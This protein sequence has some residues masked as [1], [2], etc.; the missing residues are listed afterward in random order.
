MARQV[1]GSVQPYVLGEDIENYLERVE[2]YLEVNEVDDTRKTG[3]LLT[4]GGA[5]LFDVARKV[6][7][8]QNPRNLKAD[9]LIGI[10]KQHLKATVNE[11]A[12]R[13]KFRLVYQ[14]ELS[15]K[16]YIIELKAAAQQCNFEGFLKKALRDQLVAGVADQELR[17]K[18][19]A[20][21]TLD[22]ET[23]CN[24]AFQ[25][26]ISCLDLPREC[27]KELRRN[28]Q[29]L[30]LCRGCTA[31]RCSSKESLPPCRDDIAVHVRSCLSSEFAA[32]FN[33]LRSEPETPRMQLDS[34]TSHRSA[35]SSIAHH[36]QPSRPPPLLT[37]TGQQKSRALLMV[38]PAEAKFW[39]YL[40]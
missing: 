16:D 31:T 7:A 32:S 26:H 28:P 13:Y 17:K 33:G 38:P 23:A 15:V 24:I 30:W 37:G 21:V 19:L 6:C 3:F 40:T 12:E 5:A 36:R 29:L 14:N 39:L 22:Y 9:V 10:L 11:V 2:L 4:V 20:E 8:P 27:I 35:V 34:P 1:I 25:F 18:L